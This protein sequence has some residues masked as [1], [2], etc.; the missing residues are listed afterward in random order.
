MEKISHSRLVLIYFVKNQ[1]VLEKLRFKYNPRTLQYEPIQE[2]LAE[3]VWK[4]GRAAAVV[5]LIG[6]S[7]IYI[8]FT[9]LTSPTEKRYKQEIETLREEYSHLNERLNKALYLLAELE[10]QDTLVYRAIFEAPSPR[11]PTL[12]GD[13][14]LED[15]VYRRFSS[16]ENGQL[17]K[18]IA[19]R[20]H[21]LEQRLRVQKAS[22]LEVQEWVKRKEEF[23]RNVPAIMPVNA[24]DLLTSI[25]GFG[26]RTDPVYRTP[27]FH[28]GID[29][30]T[31][32]GRP[33]FATGGGKVVFAGS[34]GSGYGLYVIIDHGFGLRT[35]Y[36]HM[37]RILVKEGQ[38]LKRGEKVGLVGC[39]GKCVGPHVHYEVR[40]WGEPVNPIHFFYGDL[41]PKEYEQLVLGAQSGAQP[42]D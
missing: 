15:S 42:L 21:W 30:I 31:A 20:L 26:M 9:F 13:N 28:T 36:A 12:R 6:A 33:I 35:L 19:L 4:V 1:T 32:L 40:R 25:G 24:R 17:L 14:H 5:L 34:D 8:S 11:R 3:R 23:T 39:T 2:P 41:S 7:A 37:S 29:F 27:R 18:D 22:L 38:V 10:K 16:L